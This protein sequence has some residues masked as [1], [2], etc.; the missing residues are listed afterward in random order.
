MFV[1][2]EELATVGRDDF[3]DPVAEDEAPIEHRHLGLAQRGVLAVQVAQGVGDG[4]HRA[5]V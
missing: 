5:S 3:V 2:A 4:L 1:E